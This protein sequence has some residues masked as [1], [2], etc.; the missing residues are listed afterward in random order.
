MGR[1][2]GMGSVALF[3]WSPRCSGPLAGDCPGGTHILVCS[4]RGRSTS[5]VEGTM[6]HSLIKSNVLI[7]VIPQFALT[8]SFCGAMRV[9]WL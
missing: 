7:Q 2:K 3:P 9:V 8:N 4:S 1:V 6:L 5:T